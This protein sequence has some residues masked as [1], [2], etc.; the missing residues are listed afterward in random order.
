[1]REVERSEDRGVK[2]QKQFKKAAKNSTQIQD[3]SR[4]PAILSSVPLRSGED[5]QKAMYKWEPDISESR[6][7]G[8]RMRS[9]IVNSSLHARYNKVQK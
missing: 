6:G 3:A 7:Q 1:M 4:G 2:R 8:E 9:S 5:R